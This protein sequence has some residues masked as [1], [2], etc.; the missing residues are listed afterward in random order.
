MAERGSGCLLATVS[1]DNRAA[2][3]LLRGLGARRV[4][5]TDRGTMEMRA[6]AAPTRTISSRCDLGMFAGRLES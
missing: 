3:A 1:M 6:S 4:G 5:P 2:V